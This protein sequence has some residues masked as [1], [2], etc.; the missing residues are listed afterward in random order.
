MQLAGL[1]EGALFA[2][3]R[4]FTNGG[5]WNKISDAPVP[6][7]QLMGFLVKMAKKYDWRGPENGPIVPPEA[8]AIE[9][10]KKYPRF[11]EWPGKFDVGGHGPSFWIEG[12]ESPKSAIVSPN[13]AA[14]P[15]RRLAIK[16]NAPN[17]GASVRNAAPAA[18]PRVWSS[19]N[20]AASVAMPPR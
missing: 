12:S 20:W 13:S 16:S 17:P 18:V 7:P 10:H 14:F 5:I 9:L 1:D 6:H 15:L 3:D 8:A 11:S 2:P 19:A 4:Y